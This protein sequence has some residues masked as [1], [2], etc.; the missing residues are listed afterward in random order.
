LIYFISQ[1]H[2]RFT[3]NPIRTSFPA[4]LLA[5][6]LSL[7]FAIVTCTAQQPAQNN[8]KTVNNPGGGQFVYGS[9]TGQSSKV[10]AMVYMLHLVHN[11]F[12]DKPQ[13]GK[14]L[15]SRDGSS[16]ATFFSLNAKTMG[17]K[18]IA[19][20]VII[21]MPAQGTPQAAVLYDDA[22]NF[23]S[24]EPSMMKS[25]SS[26]W[27]GSLGGSSNSGQGGASSQTQAPSHSGPQKLYATT[28]GDHSAMIKMPASWQLD[29]VSGGG[30]VAEGDRGEMVMMGIIFQNIVNPQNPQAQQ[31]IS[32]PM[33]TRGPKVVCPL[34]ANLFS[35]Y[36]CVFN[37]SRRNNGKA[38]GTFNFVSSTPQ[39]AGA[40]GVGQ[41]M[42]T[43]FTV[44]FH[45]GAG[46]RNGSV[47]VS[48]MAPFNPRAQTW[49]MLASM[50][51]IPQK[52]GSA[53]DPTLKAVVESYTQNASVIASEGA[54]DLNRI[55]QQGLANQAQTDAI[56]NRRE[57]GTK[58]YDSHMQALKQNDAVNDAHNG[59]IDWQSKI[60][61]DYILDRSVIR[62]SDDS[63]HALVSNDLADAL[64]KSNPNQVEIVPNQQLIRGRDF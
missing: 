43:S 63:A 17:G 41:P 46:L 13:L 64:I 32:G 50:S 21:S 39:P 33:A 5:V 11:H 42:V 60:N 35:D 58:A 2:R 57:A 3:L 45:D 6:I 61:Q 25:L 62:N 7:A 38:Q 36:V 29:R 47:Y 9:L 24:S 4:K 52:Y 26:A 12:G 14:F 48:L 28:A 15:Q 22:K 53:V 55:H 8:L 10:D 19:G 16:L 51:N 18:P 20:L 31:F 27:K 23:V 54:S 40:Q 59:E 44:D 37:Q 1:T 49:A 34:S 30:L 56:N